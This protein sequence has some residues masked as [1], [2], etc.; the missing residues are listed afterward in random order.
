MTARAII[1]GAPRSGSGKT[2]V[3]IGLLRALA[4][5]GLRA[6]G[7]KSGPDYIDPGFHTAAT[8]LPGVNL[9]SWAMAPGLLGALAGEAAKDTDIVVIESAMG[10]FDGIPAGAG[11]SGAAADLARLYGLPVLLVLDVSGQSQTAAAVAKGFACYDRDVRIAGVVLNRLGSERH[12]KLAGEAIHALGLPVVGGILRDPT[13]S[14]PERHL[15]LVQA[16]EHADL[17]KH[18]DRL[19]DMVEASLDIDAI[20]ALATPLEPP[21]A[22]FKNALPPPG[23]RIALACDAAFTFLYPHH[24][25]TWR[26]VGAEIV[27]FSPL[28][29]EA[30]PPDCDVCWLPGGYPELHAAQLSAASSFRAGVKEFAA[31]KPVHGECGGFMALGESLTDADGASHAMLGLLGHSTSFAKRKMNLGYR[32]ATLRT[33]GPL[34]RAGSVVRGH[35]FHYAQMTEAGSDEPFADLADGLGNPL[36]ASGGRRGNVSGTFFHAIAKG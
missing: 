17:Q 8:G 10:L 6:R 12:R 19:A 7:A 21:L 2:S 16:G 9:D 33:D 27:P 25:L 1:I 26:A 4:R 24:A 20:L 29:D 36:P 22:D 18:L 30:P 23:Q 32:Q 35:E 11:R 28:A 34:G 14:L 31:T 13:L 3:T 15:G 5:R